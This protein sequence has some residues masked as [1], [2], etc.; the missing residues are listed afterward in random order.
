MNIVYYVHLPFFKLKLKMG[1]SRI[2]TYIAITIASII[3]I[4]AIIFFIWNGV[5]LD[6]STTAPLG[7]IL[8]IIMIFFFT[9]FM[10][11]MIIEPM[12]YDKYEYKFEDY[13]YTIRKD[14]LASGQVRYYPIVSIAKYGVDQYIECLVVDG[15]T[16]WELTRFERKKDMREYGEP[17]SNVT[18]YY[19]SEDEAKTAINSY[20]TYTKNSIKRSKKA[21][22]KYL[23]EREG[24]KVINSEYISY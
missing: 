6:W 9:W 24:R 18:V 17:K 15:K 7:C 13:K 11:Y 21:E 2:Y 5:L 3:T 23:N 4:C 14:T 20:K 19:K 22:E 10:S 1:N 8:M 16:Y 12:L